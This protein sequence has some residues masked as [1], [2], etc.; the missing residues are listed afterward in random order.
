[1]NLEDESEDYQRGFRDGVKHREDQED[2]AMIMQV[3]F[4]KLG[5]EDLNP[6][7]LAKLDALNAKAEAA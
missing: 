6:R 4:C 1:M 2:E 7:Q 3:L 5:R